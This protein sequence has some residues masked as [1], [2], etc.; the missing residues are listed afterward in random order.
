LIAGVLYRS[1]DK[2]FVKI[3][4][5]SLAKSRG[6][7]YAVADLQTDLANEILQDLSSG[8]RKLPN[9]IKISVCE[10]LPAT[11]ND[12]S[13]RG[14]IITDEAKNIEAFGLKAFS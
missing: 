5:M 1:F 10:S 11:V 12:M 7:L 9:G 13:G 8:S 6:V 14:T 4:R 3:G 2:E